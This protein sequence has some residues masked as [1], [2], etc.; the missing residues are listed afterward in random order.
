MVKSRKNNDFSLIVDKYYLILRYRCKER[1]IVLSF[2]LKEFSYLF[3]QIKKN[4]Q[5]FI[6]KHSFYLLNIYAESLT[7]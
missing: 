7:L 5:F 6:L 3:T 2:D 4:S 1:R